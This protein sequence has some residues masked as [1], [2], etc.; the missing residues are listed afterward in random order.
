MSNHTD[1]IYFNLSELKTIE[2]HETVPTFIA[3]IVKSKV[4]QVNFLYGNIPYMIFSFFKF[5]G[6]VALRNGSLKHAKVLNFKDLVGNKGT[7]TLWRDHCPN[8]D[9][10]IV[11]KVYKFT[12][13]RVM[14]YPFFAP[15]H[16]CSKV[17]AE[18][19]HLPEKDVVYE[20]VGIE[21]GSFRGKIE[22]ICSIQPYRVCPSCNFTTRGEEDQ[23]RRC[24]GQLLG[25]AQRHFRFS[26]IMDG[27]NN[28]YGTFYGIRSQLPGEAFLDLNEDNLDELRNDL[29]LHYCGTEVIVKY[30]VDVNYDGR[31]DFRI[32]DIE[33]V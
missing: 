22:D 1:E 21:D 7:L 10:I 30:I 26:L 19:A 18:V 11:G 33:V 14:N 27:P 8:F 13:M 4:R 20:S 28:T 2:P 15:R 17:T 6:N 29:Q 23:C 3:K 31:R 16:L 5:T 12:G 32:H 9:E 25:D 24:K